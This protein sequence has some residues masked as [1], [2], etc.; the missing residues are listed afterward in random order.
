MG[1]QKA[2]RFFCKQKIEQA[3]NVT[4]FT[5][6]K[7]SK[8]RAVRFLLLTKKNEQTMNFSVFFFELF[9]VYVGQKLDHT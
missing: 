3:R 8:Q 4:F 5:N 7:M 1:K 9:K 6:K 2:L